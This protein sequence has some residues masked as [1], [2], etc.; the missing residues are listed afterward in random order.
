MCSNSAVA[1]HLHVCISRINNKTNS[2]WQPS[3]GGQPCVSLQ[4]PSLQHAPT[5]YTLHFEIQ[6][7]PWVFSIKRKCPE[8]GGLS[9][10]EHKR[11]N[12]FINLFNFYLRGLCRLKSVCNDE[13]RLH[14]ITPIT[15]WAG[16]RRASGGLRSNQWA[17]IGGQQSMIS[18]HVVCHNGRQPTTHHNLTTEKLAYLIF[19]SPPTTACQ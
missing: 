3:W 18:S 19:C 7:S 6:K 2:N 5:H 13:V 12:L 4:P 14:K 16:R 15:A 11:S 8:S 10:Q 17:S 1:E 9:G